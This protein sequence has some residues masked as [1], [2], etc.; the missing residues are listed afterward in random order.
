MAAIKGYQGAVNGVSAVVKWEID[1]EA[2]RNPA[3][4]SATEN[5]VNELEGIT[6]WKGYYVAHG[7]TPA[8]NPND[9]LTFKG[10]IDQGGTITNATAEGTAIVERWQIAW[11][12]ANNRPIIHQVQFGGNGTLSFSTTSIEDN[13]DPAW[14]MPCG[15]PVKIATPAAEPTYAELTDVISGALSY[16]AE[17]EPY[18]NSS[19]S[20]ETR[21]AAGNKQWAVDLAVHVDDTSAM[22]ALD[23]QKGVQLFVTATTYWQAEWVT[24]KKVG[25]LSVEVQGREL[26]AVHYRGMG[27]SWVDVSGTW[28]KGALTNPAT[29]DVWPPA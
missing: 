24:W 5:S 11:D 12:W 6:D 9:A 3:A 21:R 28:T 7:H 13:G 20:N 4:N 16:W 18:A 19:T 1:Q 10:T 14:Y 2:S 26:I 27:S 17:V 25:P 8:S 15:L 29:T 23:G 22:E